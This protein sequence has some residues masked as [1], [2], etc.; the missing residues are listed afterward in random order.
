MLLKWIY[1]STDRPPPPCQGSLTTRPQP[2]PAHAVAYLELAHVS[3][4]LAHMQLDG[5][6]MYTQQL[7][8]CKSS[9]A[10]ICLCAS[11]PLSHIVLH[12]PTHRWHSLVRLPSPAQLGCKSWGPLRCATSVG[13]ERFKEKKKKKPVDK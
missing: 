12:V 6:H 4:G 10:H 11:P 3:G 8:L 1:P 2:T 5:G 9:Y 7:N 13:D